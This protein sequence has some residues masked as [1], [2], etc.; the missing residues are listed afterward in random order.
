MDYF[1][2]VVN[3]FNLFQFAGSTIGKPAIGYYTKWCPNKNSI[4]ELRDILNDWKDV[5]NGLEPEQ[6]AQFEA[7][8]PGE[9]DSMMRDICS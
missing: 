6:R 1:G 3:V 2:F 9:F 7:D 8:H 5:L 4:N